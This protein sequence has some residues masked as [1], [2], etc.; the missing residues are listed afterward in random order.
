MRR[1]HSIVLHHTAG[2][3]VDTAVAIRRKHIAKGWRD[4]GYHCIITKAG[5]VWHIEAG[6]PEAV[7]GAHA[8]RGFPGNTGSLGIAVCGNYVN[9][10]PPVEA[11]DIL[12]HQI[13]M[14]NIRYSG[15]VTGVGDGPLRVWGHCDLN[16]TACP[17]TL[18][19]V[20]P[21]IRDALIHKRTLLDHSLIRPRIFAE[22]R[23]EARQYFAAH[24]SWAKAAA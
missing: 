7:V 4:I 11:L 12:F 17:G 15:T 21:A 18:Y 1:V 13:F 8:G 24:Q 5:G 6:R 16:M 10:L 22:A 3:P 20:I 2:S 14:W 19:N 9:A 23:K